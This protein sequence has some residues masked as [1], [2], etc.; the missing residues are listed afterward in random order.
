M[1]LCFL[2]MSSSSTFVIQCLGRSL[3][4]TNSKKYAFVIFPLIEISEEKDIN[5]FLRII[6]KSDIKLRER[7][8]SKKLGGYINIDNVKEYNYETEKCE[9]LDDELSELKYELVFSSLGTLIEKKINDDFE[10]KIQEVIEF[11]NQNKCAPC[12]SMSSPPDE[13]KLGNWI[14]DIVRKYKNNNLKFCDSKMIILDEFYKNYS[15]YFLTRTE[16][17]DQKM[18]LLKEFLDKHKRRPLTDSKNNI[19][20]TLGH[21]VTSYVWTFE[22]YKRKHLFSD[23]I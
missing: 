23:E 1:S 4:K 6:S 3:R 12:R 13:K 14:C 8:E 16:Q 19:E 11:I 2:N 17:F 9:S 15:N 7:Y 22:F 18:N 5:Q 20:K 10:K 21:F